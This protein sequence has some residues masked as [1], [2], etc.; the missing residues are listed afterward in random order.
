[1]TA[2]RRFRPKS[3]KRLHE[4]EEPPVDPQVAAEL[5]MERGCDEVALPRE[6]DS[7]PVAGEWRARP[8]RA[9]DRRRPDEDRVERR[10]EPVDDEVRLER[11]PLSPERVPVHRHVHEAEELRLRFVGLDPGVLREQDA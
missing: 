7:I 3:R 1:M 5:W 8:P 6:D 2:T 9:Q 4:I 11:F 10:I